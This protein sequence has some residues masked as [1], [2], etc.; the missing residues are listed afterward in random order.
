M[1]SPFREQIGLPLWARPDLGFG[2]TGLGPESSLDVLSALSPQ[3]WLAPPPQ[4][5]FG[6]PLEFLIELL[7]RG[8][9][10]QFPGIQQVVP[11]QPFAPQS[12][13]F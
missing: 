2:E 6:V 1:D 9:R 5:P 11:Q 3:P 10:P 7:L 4:G 12:M 13:R 8:A